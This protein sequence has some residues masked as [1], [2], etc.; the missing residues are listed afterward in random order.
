MRLL[1]ALQ[2][3]LADL[4]RLASINQSDGAFLSDLTLLD[5]LDWPFESLC[6][7]KRESRATQVRDRDACIALFQAAI[8]VIFCATLFCNLF[9]PLPLPPHSSHLV[10]CGR[11]DILLISSFLFF[12]FPPSSSVHQAI[13]TATQPRASVETD[14]DTHPHTIHTAA[15][16]LWRH[17]I[18]ASTESRPHRGTALQPGSNLQSAR[19]AHTRH[20]LQS[21]C[22]SRTLGAQGSIC[23]KPNHH[24]TLLRICRRDRPSCR[25]STNLRLRE[26]REPSKP[27]SS[28]RCR[29]DLTTGVANSCNSCNSC[30]SWRAPSVRPGVEGSS[31]SSAC[32]LLDFSSLYFLFFFPL[33]DFALHRIHQLRFR[34]F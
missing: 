32:A 14:R 26:R 17:L 12:L 25:I 30:N 7:A 8:V 10:A 19:T 24:P 28:G 21:V 33:L 4:V 31:S 9:L 29:T 23:P 18:S 15:T 1:E 22:S 11:A 16:L 6:V 13:A 34:P 2:S 20:N 27:S 3:V 5:L